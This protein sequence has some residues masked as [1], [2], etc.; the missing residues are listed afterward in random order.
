MAFP[1]QRSPAGST[2]PGGKGKAGLLPGSEWRACSANFGKGNVNFPALMEELK[3]I[4]YDGWGVVEQDV[5]P[6]MGQPR[7][8]PQKQGI[9]P[10]AGRLSG[11]ARISK[12]R[13]Y[14]NGF[15][16][17]HLLKGREP[18]GEQTKRSTNK[19]RCRRYRRYGHQTRG[20]FVPVRWRGKVVASMTWIKT[21]RNRLLT[22]AVTHGVFDDPIQLIEDLRWKLV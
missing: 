19:S 13:L 8:P 14:E 21:G 2:Y 4:G 6:G 9:H 3:R 22:R 5:L 17:Q 7:N 16:R 12:F 10:L 1:L 11:N 18:D 15:A 20:Q